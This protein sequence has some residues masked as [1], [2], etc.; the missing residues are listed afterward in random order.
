MQKVR[1]KETIID[2]YIV[3]QI[4]FGPGGKN[5]SFVTMRSIKQKNN[6]HWFGHESSTFTVVSAGILHNGGGKELCQKCKVAPLA[7]L[8]ELYVISL[9]GFHSFSVRILNVCS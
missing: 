6:G 3:I 7:D 1:V 2:F 4:M 9:L 8:V 5:D